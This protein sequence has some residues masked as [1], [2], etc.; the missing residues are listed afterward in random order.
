M[1]TTKTTPS[2]NFNAKVQIILSQNVEGQQV[3]RH[4]ITLND[5]FE[6]KT[7][8]MVVGA[9]AH[10]FYRTITMTKMNGN[11]KGLSL[12]TP[13]EFQLLADDVLLVDSVKMSEDLKC[14]I[15]IGTTKKGQMRFARLLATTLHN[16]LVGTFTQDAYRDALDEENTFTTEQLMASVRAL[17]DQPFLA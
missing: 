4:A 5:N 13:F 9:L 6:G 7:F 16:E 10:R 8:G 17:L 11:G 14:R 1:K 15:T 3:Y 12:R 2:T